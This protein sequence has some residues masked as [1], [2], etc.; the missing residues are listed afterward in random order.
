MVFQLKLGTHSMS[1]PFCYRITHYALSIDIFKN[2]YNKITLFILLIS[3]YSINDI[4][5]LSEI[6]NILISS[7]YSATLELRQQPLILRR[8]ASTFVAMT[9][10]GT[11]S[12]VNVIQQTGRECGALPAAFR[13]DCLRQGFG[14][15]ANKGG[16]GSSSGAGAGISSSFGNASDDYSRVSRELSSTSRQLAAL[17]RTNTDP[18]TKPIKKNGR[19]Y[20]A[21]KKTSLVSVNTRASAVLSETTT[22]L[23]RSAGPSQNQKG[24][25]QKIAN[26]VGST[27]RLLRS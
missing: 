21:V 9:N 17:V 19:I 1:A 23:I 22:K 10:S 18:S 27:K 25:I 14:R 8:S 20:R 13:V 15:A 16:G 3:I 6:K 24:H 11:N 26:A 5:R 4:L 7:A 2:I 12:F